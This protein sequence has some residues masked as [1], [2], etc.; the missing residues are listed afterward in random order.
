VQS[1][2]YYPAS[3]SNGLM[4]TY[5]DR[6]TS[7]SCG[8]PPAA[9]VNIWLVKHRRRLSKLI[10][11]IGSTLNITVLSSLYFCDSRLWHESPYYLCNGVSPYLLQTGKDSSVLFPILSI[12]CLYSVY[13]VSIL[14]P[15]SFCHYYM[16]IPSPITNPNKASPRSLMCNKL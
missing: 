15:V 8:P 11:I 10:M 5:S 1:G 14:S 16:L 4:H 3:G 13:S 7:R 6:A 12:F 9:W 2:Q